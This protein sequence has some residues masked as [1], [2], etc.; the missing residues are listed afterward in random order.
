MSGQVPLD[1][2]S[3][4]R[5]FEAYDTDKNGYITKAEARDAIKNSGEPPGEP[6]GEIHKALK[7]FDAEFDKYDTN[8]DGKVLFEE[9]IAAIGQP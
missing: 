4:L 3:M 9:V 8:K 1:R 2:D 6:P 7:E 5:I